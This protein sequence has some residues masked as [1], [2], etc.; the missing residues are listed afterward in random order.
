[1]S[2]H[3]GGLPL[4]RRLLWILIC[5]LAILMISQFVVAGWDVLAHNNNSGKTDQSQYLRIAMRIQAGG[6]FTDGNRQPLFPLLLAPLAQRDVR[7]FT[8]AKMLSLV[9]GVLG[10]MIIGILSYRRFGVVPA[11]VTIFLLSLNASYIHASGLVAC[12]P[13]LMLLFFLAWYMAVP[14]LKDWRAAAVAGAFTGLAYLA[15]AS[16]LTLLLAFV[17]VA[18]IKFR[19]DVL[20]QKSIWAFLIAYV[21]ISLPL[22]QYNLREYGDPFYNYNTRHAMWMDDWSESREYSEDELPT[23]SSYLQTHSLQDMVQRELAGFSRY[24]LTWRGSS[25][26]RVKIAGL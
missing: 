22:F 14:G 23:L 7:F 15:K 25:Y 6:D 5:L 8:Y 19:K 2:N 21:L 16:G 3:Q 1:M 4:T 18:V 10:L 24:D 13:L 12:E 9:I 20:R 17:A 26:R 11:L